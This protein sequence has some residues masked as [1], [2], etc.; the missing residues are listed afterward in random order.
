MKSRM[1][2]A[3]CFVMLGFV[4]ATPARAQGTWIDPVAARALIVRGGD[5]VVLDARG[6]K[7]YAAGH[8]E[9][10]VSAPWAAFADMNGKPGGANWGTVLPPERLGPVIGGLGIGS[11]TRVLVYSGSPQG[12]GEDG[13]VAWTLR[14]AGVTNVAIIDGGYE[15]WVASGGA[16]SRSTTGAKPVAFAVK[17]MDRSLNVNKDEVKAALG[18]ARII[19]ARALDEYQG[20]QKYGEARGGRLPGA[21]SLP[22]NSVFEANGRMRTPDGLRQLLAKAGI[23][24]GD[25]IIA[26]CTKGIRSAHLTLVLK[27]LGYSKVRNYD[28]SF[29]EWAG[30]ASLPLEK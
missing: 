16:T 7:D 27:E 1:L 9:G 21:V 2:A 30:D 24:P 18:K 11:G 8:V 14:M 12:W 13:R 26:Y 23:K 28:A 17:A 25:D 10:A 5:I 3:L 15:G 29:H 19:D 20:A 4:A 22:W 6:A